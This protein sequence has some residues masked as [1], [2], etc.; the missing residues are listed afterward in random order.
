VVAAEN[1]EK[2]DVDAGDLLGDLLDDVSTVDG[3]GDLVDQLENG[4][5]AETM[6]GANVTNKSL[7]AARCFSSHGKVERRAHD[8]IAVENNIAAVRR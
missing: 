3:A 7:P 2:V 5:L 6:H 4:A 1:A 8:D